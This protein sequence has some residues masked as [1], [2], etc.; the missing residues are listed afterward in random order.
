M[1]VWK[2]STQKLGLYCRENNRYIWTC[3]ECGHERLYN[4]TGKRRCGVNDEL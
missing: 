1:R 2:C 4:F 3:I